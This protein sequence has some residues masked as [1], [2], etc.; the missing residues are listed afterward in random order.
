MNVFLFIHLLKDPKITSSLEYINKASLDVDINI[1]L[2]PQ[3]LSN[4][5]SAQIPDQVGRLYLAL[6]RNCLLK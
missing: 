3:N 5:P 1:L 6:I 2:D 4:Y